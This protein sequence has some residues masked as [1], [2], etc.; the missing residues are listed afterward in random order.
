MEDRQDCAE[1][2]QPPDNGQGG[3]SHNVQQFV[4]GYGNGD[5][6]IAVLFDGGD[7]QEG[8]D[9]RG[10][11]KFKKS[12]VMQY[13]HNS[14]FI[15]SKIYNSYAILYYFWGEGKYKNKC[16]NIGDKGYFCGGAVFDGVCIKCMLYIKL[17]N[18][19]DERKC[20]STLYIND[21]S[22]SAEEKFVL[23]KRTGLYLKKYWTRGG[24]SVNIYELLQKQRVNRIDQKCT[25]K[26]A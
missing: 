10:E 9:Q 19:Y 4:C 14:P 11:E 20:V 1:G 21:F 2:D 3:I 17:C 7:K 6:H 8:S 25:R 23:E 5:R 24:S 26:S 15:I 16:C 13:V 22:V 18:W 12:L